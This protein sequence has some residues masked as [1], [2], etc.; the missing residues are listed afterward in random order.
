MPQHAAGNELP[1][2]E[3]LEQVLGEGVAAKACKTIAMRTAM[4]RFIAAAIL[5]RLLHL[6][7]TMNIP[8]NSYR[9]KDNLEAGVVRSHDENDSQPGWE[10]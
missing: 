6:A 4:A 9:L 5:D 1:Y 8:S 3:F 10:I 2:A 7:V